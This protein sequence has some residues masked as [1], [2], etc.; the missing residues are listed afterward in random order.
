MGRGFSV[1]TA[2]TTVYEMV[3]GEAVFAR[4]VDHFY[5]LVEADPEL[6]P[7]FPDD[8]QAGK[9]WQKLFLIQ[10]FGGPAAYSQERGHPRLRQRHLPFRI[11]Q[12]ARDRWLAHM[13]AAMRSAG[14]DEPAFSLMQAYF[15]RASAFMINADNLLHW[16]PGEQGES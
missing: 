2:E 12:A 9:R 13:L 14:I 10:L 8:L 6:R 4:L 16:R 5:A 15:E 3:G 11:D 7:L 1:S